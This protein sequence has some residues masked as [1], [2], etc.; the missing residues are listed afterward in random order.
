MSTP[1]RKHDWLEPPEWWKKWRPLRWLLGALLLAGLWVAVQP[2]LP[3]PA[4]QGAIATVPAAPSPTPVPVVA[5]TPDAA[6][7]PGAEVQP[8]PAP[9]PHTGHAATASASDTAAEPPTEPVAARVAEDEAEVYFEESLGEPAAD[10]ELAAFTRVEPDPVRLLGPYR[11]YAS[12]D[13]VV[14]DLERAGFAPIVESRHLPV[15]KDVPPRDLDTVTVMQ[16]R[17]WDVPGRLQLQFFNDRLYQTE[18]EPEDPARYQAAQRRELPQLGREPSGRSEYI[19][20][21]LRIASSLDLAISEV[22]RQL[23]TRPFLIWQDRRLVRQR[24]EWDRRFAVA[25]VP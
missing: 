3:E 9:T 8:T 25:A 7:S 22:G 21:H 19:A 11:S 13:E 1:E 12:V 24:E 4:P 18:F 23:G 6:T 15:R 10:S 2:L 20:G 17:H 14:F 16:Y 5:A